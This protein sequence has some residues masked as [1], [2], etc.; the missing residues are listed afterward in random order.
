MRYKYYPITGI[1]AGW[2][3]DGKLPLRQNIDEWY[4]KEENK[5]QVV[6]F[7]LALKRFQDMP[8]DQRDSFFQ[9][10]GQAQAFSGYSLLYIYASIM[11]NTTTCRHSWYALQIVGRA[12]HYT[13]RSR[14]ERLL[15]SCELFV[16]AMAQAIST[17]LRGMFLAVLSLATSRLFFF[18]DRTLLV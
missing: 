12:K 3:P 10:A 9:I 2:G 15:H 14:Q 17:S 6:L 4:Q 16:P 13:G 1:K 11:F 7:L 5:A 18:F 8:P